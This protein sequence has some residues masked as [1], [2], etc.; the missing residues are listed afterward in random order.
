MASIEREVEIAL[1]NAVSAASI[2]HTYTSER[3]GARLLPSLVARAAISSELLGTFTGVFD[4]SATLTYTSRADSTT[5]AG[6]DH[7]AQTIV[8]EL[9]RDPSLTEYLTGASNLTFYRASII[10]DTGAII[11]TNRTWQRTI[12]IDVQATAKK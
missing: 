6:F 12:T 9:Y 5:R 11:S 1:L 10:S 8:Q 3:Q 4:I 7:E 2:P